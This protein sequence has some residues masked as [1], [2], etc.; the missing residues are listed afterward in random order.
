MLWY[1]CKLKQQ[2]TTI[3]AKAAAAAVETATTAATSTKTNFNNYKAAAIHKTS[4]C[5][6]CFFL[7][8]YIFCVG[9]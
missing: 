5:C 3:D 8:S 7:L 2:L 1:V 4:V 6:R 9:T